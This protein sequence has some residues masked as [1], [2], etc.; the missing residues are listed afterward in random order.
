MIESP[1][2]SCNL[3]FEAF[4][5]AHSFAAFDWIASTF[6]S[7]FL[8][9]GFRKSF[10]DSFCESSPE[11]WTSGGIWNNSSGISWFAFRSVKIIRIPSAL[12]FAVLM[13]LIHS[14]GKD[15]FLDKYTIADSS[16]MLTS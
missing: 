11:N 16:G 9:M 3:V 1:F 13:T 10:P 7:G 2:S 5:T 15:V 4:V 8:R 14:L 6:G 12:S